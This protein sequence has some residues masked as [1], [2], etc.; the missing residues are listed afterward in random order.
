MTDVDNEHWIFTVQMGLYR[1]ARDMNIPLVDITAKSGIKEFAPDWDFLLAYKNGEI[2]VTEYTRRYHAK[3]IGNL[4]QD[5]TLWECFLH[6]PTIAL[7]CYCKAGDFCHRY[8]FTNLLTHYLQQN[9][10]IV[11]YQGE[12]LPHPNND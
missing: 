2:S 8:L 6:Q 4:E 10:K 7:A 3:V 11:I 12:L 9:G 1:Y 5:K